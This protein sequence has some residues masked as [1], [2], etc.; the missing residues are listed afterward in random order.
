MSVIDK[1]R[2]D[3]DAARQKLWEAEA[4]ARDRA[5]AALVG[6]CFRYRNSYSCPTK[7]EDYWFMYVKV[8]AAKDGQVSVFQ[9]QTDKDGKFSIDPINRYCSLNENYRPIT[10]KQFAAAWVSQNNDVRVA[11]QAIGLQSKGHDDE[12]H[13]DMAER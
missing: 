11:A 6:K 2:K 13:A 3:A 4:V 7:P 1:L 10:E 5:N 12:V 8:I 9:F